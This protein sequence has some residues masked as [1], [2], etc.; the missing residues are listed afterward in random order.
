MGVAGKCREVWKTFV[1]AVSSETSPQRGL[2]L[3]LA[4]REAPGKFREYDPM[5]ACMDGHQNAHGGTCVPGC[6]IAGE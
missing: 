2:K 5:R 6:V 1:D 4:S 3:A